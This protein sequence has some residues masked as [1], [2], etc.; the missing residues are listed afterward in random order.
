MEENL[1]TDTTLEAVVLDKMAADLTYEKCT[2][3]EFY[4]KDGS[5]W[6]WTPKQV[7]E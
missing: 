1:A 4:A 5:M 6:V 2:R 3:K 7:T